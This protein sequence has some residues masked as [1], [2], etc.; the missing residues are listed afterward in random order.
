MDEIDGALVPVTMNG[1]GGAE[2]TFTFSED[3]S[4]FQ[5]HF[6]A[7]KILPGICQVQ[8]VLALLSR[9]QDNSP[10]LVEITSAKYVLPIVPGETIT[11]KIHGL[12]QNGDSVLSL[13]ASILKGSER[14]S[15][16]RLKVR[17]GS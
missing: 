16:F 6:P 3:F 2:A 1:T 7:G 9:W 10:R 12:K 17:S 4:G 5:G 15:D 13:K 8:C 11:C 14:V